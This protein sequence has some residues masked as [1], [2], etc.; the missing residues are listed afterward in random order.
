MGRYM[1]TTVNDVIVESYVKLPIPIQAVQWNDDQNSYFKLIKMGAIPHIEIEGDGS[2]Y[3]KT[4][5]GRMK[6][7][8]GSYVIKGVEGEFYACNEEIFNKTYKKV[9]NV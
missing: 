4:L 7:P 3:I 5:E 2:L 1:G 8:I 6:C 9:E